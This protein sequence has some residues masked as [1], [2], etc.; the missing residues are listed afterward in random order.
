MSPG[1]L[2]R[3]KGDMSPLVQCNRH[4]CPRYAAGLLRM[5]IPA[6]GDREH[7]VPALM[8]P[9]PLALC[10]A[11]AKEAKAEQ[12]MTPEWRMQMRTVLRNRGALAV[13]D[14]E[15]AWVELLSFQDAEDM[16]GQLEQAGH[17]G[18]A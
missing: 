1:I 8:L 9:V 11:H 17:A 13:P 18:H 12:F 16:A 14:F 7:K 10:E 2:V 5:C 4:G 3:Q 6:A 15:N